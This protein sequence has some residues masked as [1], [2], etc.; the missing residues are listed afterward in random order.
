MA[1]GG[2]RGVKKRYLTVL[3]AGGAQHTCALSGGR[4]GVEGERRMHERGWKTW[5]PGEMGANRKRTKKFSS[6]CSNCS[7]R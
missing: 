6:D 7:V 1:A 3:K 4:V 5:V 2:K